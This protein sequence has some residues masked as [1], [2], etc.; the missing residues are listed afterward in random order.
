MAV[1]GSETDADGALSRFD[2]QLLARA[3]RQLTQPPQSTLTE[4][5]KIQADFAASV[6]QSILSLFTEFHARVEEAHN[7]RFARSQSRSH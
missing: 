6:P 4:L 7:R 3:C 2:T 5:G 1:E